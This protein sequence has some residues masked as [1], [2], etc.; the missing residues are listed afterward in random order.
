ML[1]LLRHLLVVVRMVRT[2]RAYRCIAQAAAAALLVFATGLPL[3]AQALAPLVLTSETTRVNPWETI[4]L[5]ADPTYQLTAQDMLGRLNEFEQPARRGGS[6]GIHKAAM[7]LRIPVIAPQASNT[8][9][10]VDIGYAS[11]RADIY[12][13]SGGKLVQQLSDDA[14]TAQLSSRTPAMAF[15]LQP[16]QP[17]DLLIRIQ[18]TGPLILPITIGT[19]PSQ[20]H[21]ALRDQM[22]QGLLNGLAFFLLAYSLIQW[23]TQRERLF[24]FYALVVIGSA[25]FS[26]QFFGIGAQFLWPDNVWM[27]R[28]GGVAAGLTALAGSFLFLGH[29]LSDSRRP[30]RYTRIM[31][32]G[33]AITGTLCVAMML[34]WVSVPIAIAFMSLVGPLPS[35]LSVPAAL[36][37]VRKKD[38]IG[39]TLLVAWVAYGVAAA[40]MVCLVQGW[41]PANFWTMH[42]FQFGATVDMLLFLRVMGLRARAIRVEAQEARRDG[43]I[44]RRLAHSDPLTGLSNRRGLQRELNTALEWCSPNRLVAVYLIDLDGFKP[45]NDK[46]GHDVGD[47]LLVA[48]G[49]RLQANVRQHIDV[50]ARLGGDEFIILAHDLETPQQA[51]DIGMA[52]LTAF[53]HTFALGPLQID[54]GLT[55]G[56]ALA[57]LDAQDAQAMV[58]LADSAM[59]AGKQDGKRTLRRARGSNAR[60]GKETAA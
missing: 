34:G 7:W 10:V 45:I 26:L 22:L 44:M 23:I 54:V 17:Y 55:I 38:A 8:P 49:H 3:P 59:Y 28:H 43:E 21:H 50:V 12:L 42:S 20:L 53:D 32:W 36:A 56:Y 16:G 9:W 40:V 57:P 41:V 52:L 35:I 29:A 47:D 48:V 58:R 19:M 18:A 14:A 2:G 51:E 37:L 27:A 6:L 46:Y 39:A 25:G 24:A 1:L 4:T 11:L 15:E 13:A 33:A 31:R 30:T 5:K 60:A